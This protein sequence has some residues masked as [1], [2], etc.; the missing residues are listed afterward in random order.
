MDK[1][2]FI[3]GIME[4]IKLTPYEKRAEEYSRQAQKGMIYMVNGNQI[5]M[6][7]F[8][9]DEKEKSTVYRAGFRNSITNQTWAEWLE[10]KEG[11]AILKEYF[12]D[13]NRIDL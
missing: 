4:L 6:L 9:K 7:N 11:A 8:L 3:A 5:F 12:S 2:K 10:E 13:P 1:E